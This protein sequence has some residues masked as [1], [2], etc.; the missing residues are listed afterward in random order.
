MTQ[1]MIFSDVRVIRNHRQNY[2]TSISHFRI[3]RSKD[4]YNF[5]FDDTPILPDSIYE[6]FG[7]EDLELLKLMTNTTFHIPLLV[8]ME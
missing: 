6:E 5:T 1:I 2:L 8:N 4:G 3:C 7:I